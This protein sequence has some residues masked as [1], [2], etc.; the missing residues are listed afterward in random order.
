[1]FVKICGITSA[2]DASAAA[3]AGA[4][5]I[6]LVLA[7]SARRVQPD[8]AARIARSVPKGILAVAVVADIGPPEV[9]A[10]IAQTGIEAVQLHGNHT[11]E[12]VSWLSERVPVVIK[13]MAAGSQDLAEVATW[14]ASA[15]LV[16]AQTPGSG[17]SFDWAGLPALGDTT[18]IIV[19]GGLTASNVSEAIAQAKPWG[20][21]VS[22]GVELSPGKKDEKK[23][24]AFVAAARLAGPP[25]GD[26]AGR[27][28]PY[29]W[30]GGI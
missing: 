3:S 25:V 4:D 2:A 5:A 24:R 29:D 23:M 8:E 13:A 10:L 9:M 14:G 6:G 18:R 16:D 12:E 11:A 30:A 19:A 7:R 27:H 1:M 21:D 15:I 26:T 28:G 22:T 20:V 17:Q